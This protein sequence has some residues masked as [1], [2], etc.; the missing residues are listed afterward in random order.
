MLTIL[1]T[2]W[3][4]LKHTSIHI[5]MIAVPAFI[6]ICSAS[7]FSYQIKF[8]NSL[9]MEGFFSLWTAV[10]LP[11]IVGV[12][13][14]YLVQEEEVAGNFTGFL[15]TNISRGK[16]Y[17]GKLLMIWFQVSIMT[18]IATGILCFGVERIRE[19]NEAIL[20]FSIAS[21]F[22]I[23]G[24]LPIIGIALWVSFL[25]GMGASIGVGIISLLIGTLLGTTNLGDGIWF[26]V[27]WCWDIKISMLPNIYFF[28]GN[29]EILSEV[30]VQLIQ[31]I[32]LI[33][34]GFFLFLLGGMIWF[35][36]WEGRKHSEV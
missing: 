19:D 28:Q 4:K 8:Q 22:T 13:A 24:T 7:Y 15:C 33:T 6:S 2:E 3:L 10:I 20:A 17:L 26:F 14:G 18:I 23:I 35:S 30:M 27:P 36:R 11:L 9:I 34:I 5:M 31:I 32:F 29:R 1:S 16:L 25:W 21:F 12:L